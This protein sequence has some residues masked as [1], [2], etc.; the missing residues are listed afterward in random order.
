MPRPASNQPQATD[1]TPIQ[2][3]ETPGASERVKTLVAEG[4]ENQ[5]PG[6]SAREMIAKLRERHQQR[7][8]RLP[9]A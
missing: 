7:W 5:Q 4:L 2:G 8:G 3:G 1:P 9:D 6:I